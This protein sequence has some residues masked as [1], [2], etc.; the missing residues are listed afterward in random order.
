M[1]A[2]IA[3]WREEQ[4]GRDPRPVAAVVETP[5]LF[6]A[7]MAGIY[8][9][10]IAVVADEQLRASRAQ[11]RGHHAVDERTARQLSQDEKASRATY[12]VRNDSSV[13][14]LESE[15]AVILSHL[16]G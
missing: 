4:G 12:A 1:G 8:D 10:T 13:A 11:A 7:G 9:A 3:A 5:L 14:A 15:L 6:E 2:R 16:R